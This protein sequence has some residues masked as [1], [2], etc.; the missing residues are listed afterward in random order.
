MTVKGWASL[1]AEQSSA[2]AMELCQRPGI[3][4]GKTWSAL[5]GIYWIH[6]NRPDMRHASEMAAELIARAEKKGRPENIAF[7][8]YALGIAKM[9]SG[10]FE[11]AALSFDRG[12]ALFEST[13]K[14]VTSVTLQILL[15]RS[16]TYNQ[17][18]KDLLAEAI[19]IS[20]WNLWFL[21]YPDRQR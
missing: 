15:Q 13:A 3:N 2:R 16:R 21:G 4:W 11:F 10:D 19:V 17:E 18:R 12:L 14:P 8:A 5:I 7:A 1:E 9:F 6:L 20:A